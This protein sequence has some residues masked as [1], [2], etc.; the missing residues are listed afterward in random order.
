V[1]GRPAAWWRKP[2]R[3]TAG[4]KTAGAKTAGM[5]T[6]GAKTGAE[7]KA[8][9]HTTTT[10]APTTTGTGTT[11]P[12]P[13]GATAV[14]GARAVAADLE[15]ASPDGPGEASPRAASQ[16]WG[17]GTRWPTLA[18][19]AAWMLAVG[20]VAFMVHANTDARPYLRLVDL[21]VYRNGGLSVLHDG[22]L[23]AQV[24]RGHLLFTYPPVAAVLAVPLALMPWATAILAWLPMI[25]I[26]L[27]V[28]VWIAFRPLL[29]R[30]GPW[31]PA[32]YALLLLGCAFL[33]PLRQEIHY[34]QVDIFLVALCLLDCVTEKPRWP[35]GALIGVATA[36]KLVPGVFIVYLL[37]TGRRKAAGVATL[38]FAAVSGLA[39][40]VAP[41]DSSL[42]WTKV[43][44]ESGRLGANRQA[45]NQSLRGILM[46]LFWPSAMPVAVWAAV[47]LVVAVA[48]FAA[49]R[50]VHAR[51]P[52]LGGV[53]ITGLLAALLSPVA[54]IHHICWIV[55]VIGVIVGD[56]RNPR[57][58]ITALATG[59]VFTSVL[60]IFGKHLTVTGAVPIVIGRVL[61][62]SFGLAALVLIWVVWRLRGTGPH[63]IP[64]PAPAP[65]GGSAALAEREL[66]ASS[67]ER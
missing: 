7:T 34:G 38:A 8:A 21:N 36:I 12:A 25:Y 46:R 17:A 48:G 45:A 55:V 67:R 50:A 57:R 58:V 10:A 19:V 6:A 32:V 11:A 65:G 61:E 54:W 33:M 51:G 26:P 42:Y 53:A 4:A 39:W 66:L 3:L 22:A 31:R 63:A 64:P 1:T 14:A 43:I 9:A 15:V 29:A 60:P 44:F 5:Q 47:A 30:C 56:G 28:V 59:A 52:E 18:A 13:T 16:S 37:I 62:D 2:G 40:A 20:L 41:Q 27:A 23:Y 35:R 24:S 49:A